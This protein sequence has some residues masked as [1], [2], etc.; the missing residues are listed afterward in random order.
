[1]A[2]AKE[3]T[4]EDIDAA[5]AAAVAKVQDSVEKLEA[6]NKELIGENRKL[7]SAGEIKPEDLAAAEER[8]DKAEAALAAA[9]KE[10]KDAKAAADKATKTL[11]AEQGFTQK[12][13]IQDG[14][15][16]AL[17]ANGV[18]DEDFIDSLTAKFSS[19]ASINA[20]GETRTAIYGDKPLG[21]FIKEWAA[22]DAGKKFIAAP[23][24]SGG[25]AGG[26]D[27]KGATGKTMT[28]SAFDALGQGERASFSKEGGRVVDG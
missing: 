17:I 25:G 15:K 7:K 21:D 23:S 28:R 26:G 4:Q 10:A 12:L 13:L 2:D 27:G 5:V 14:I 8:A 11:E 3:L 22:S 20:D 19:G 1:M 9:Q 24:N 6:K 18:K 16:S